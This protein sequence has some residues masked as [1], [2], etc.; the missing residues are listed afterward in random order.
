LEATRWQY[1]TGVPDESLVSPDAWLHDH[2]LLS[3]RGNDEIQLA[4]FRDYATNP[5]LYPRLHEYLRSSRV[6]VLA[7]WGRGD[8]IF[9]PAGAQAFAEDAADAEIHL[10]DG[11]HF[12]L[13][14]AGD[15]VAA[16]IRDFLGRRLDAPKTTLGLE[17][18][19]LPVT[20]IDRALSFYTEQVGFSLD[21]DYRPTPEFRV[22]QLTPPGSACSVQLVADDSRRVHDLYLVTPDLAATRAELIARG[23]P[24]GDAR[25]KDP[26]ETWA[27]G[28]A[29]G[30][31]DQRRDYASFADFADPDGN[32]W[33][34]QERR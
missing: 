14:S 6:P 9:G 32:T 18:V 11:G 34:L 24:V 3:R 20:D 4:L 33:T 19:P 7:V 23:V 16:L 13:E 15:Q 27:G 30:S 12:L 22:V 21:V 28:F 17:V 29:P 25:H 31:D 26:V 1:V 8:E 5:P 2:A 10:L